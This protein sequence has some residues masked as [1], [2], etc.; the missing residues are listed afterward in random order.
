MIANLHADD[1]GQCLRGRERIKD[2]LGV[3]QRIKRP[4][5]RKQNDRIR[6]VR[7][8]PLDLETELLDD[9]PLTF[10]LL[11]DE[12]R[13]E[14]VVRQRGYEENQLLSQESLPAA[15]LVQQPVPSLCDKRFE[16]GIAD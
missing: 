10:A 12:V 1:F 2:V 14:S 16:R 8:A 6:V 13:E 9:I 4:V 15:E 5:A 7:S 3:G 11:Q